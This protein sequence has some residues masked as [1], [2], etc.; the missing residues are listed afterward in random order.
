MY[1]KKASIS[2]VILLLLVGCATIGIKPW[3]DRS[4]QE[5]ASY[6]MSIYNKEFND[7]RLV[8]TNPNITDTQRKVVRIKKEILTKLWLAIGAYDS[9]VIRGEIPSIM[10]EQ[11]ILDYI[12]QLA[13]AGGV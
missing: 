11:K 6:F 12:N 7:T 4:P 3:A 10:D 2:V 9:I 8:A 5:K 13:T 1:N